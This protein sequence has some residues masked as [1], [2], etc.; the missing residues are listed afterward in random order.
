MDIII[1]VDKL[2]Q[3]NK[4]NSACKYYLSKY[5]LP[6]NCQLYFLTFC[7]SF[8]DVNHV[9]TNMIQYIGFV[10]YNRGSPCFRHWKNF[11]GFA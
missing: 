10:F 1:N 6:T 2:N 11:R 8:F 9:L 7:Y 5:T 4:E 3:L